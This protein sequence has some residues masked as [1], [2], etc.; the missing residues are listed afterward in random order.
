MSGS[1]VG[2]SAAAMTS[3]AE[4]P[5]AIGRY[6]ELRMRP[7][8]QRVAASERATAAYLAHATQ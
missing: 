6:Q 4:L 8:A 7:A 5:G 2:L 3:A 1:L